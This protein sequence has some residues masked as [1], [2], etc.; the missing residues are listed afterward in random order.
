MLPQ[1]VNLLLFFITEAEA[2]CIIKWMLKNSK[3]SSITL[4]KHFVEDEKIFKI[5]C[6]N[7]IKIIS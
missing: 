3:N 1:V 4:K 5:L 2:Y 6:Q 7:F